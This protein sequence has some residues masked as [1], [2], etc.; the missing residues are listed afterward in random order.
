MVP[1]RMAPPAGSAGQ[2]RRVGTSARHPR[3]GGRCRRRRRR[4]RLLSATATS[5]READMTPEQMTKLFETHR[6]AEARRDYDAIID[7]FT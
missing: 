6:E 7:T 4:S 1:V 5:Q 2:T 3:R